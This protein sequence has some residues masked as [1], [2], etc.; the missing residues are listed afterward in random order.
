LSR[1]RESEFP[2]P[3]GVSLSH[4]RRLDKVPA[5]AVVLRQEPDTHGATLIID[6]LYA[7]AWLLARRDHAAAFLEERRPRWA[8]VDRHEEMPG[9]TPDIPLAWPSYVAVSDRYAYV[10]DTINRRV[11]RV[12]AVASAVPKIC[13]RA[14]RPTTSQIF[15]RNS[16]RRTSCPSAVSTFE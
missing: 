9:L 7:K 5:V 11:V 4:E 13:S 8:D 15:S 1:N 12:R 6:A 2:D 10:A 14:V 16:G 3:G